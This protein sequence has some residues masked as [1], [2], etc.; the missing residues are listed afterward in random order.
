MQRIWI[1]ACGAALA[2]AA[3]PL[4][5]QNTRG[6]NDSTFVWSGRLSD[7]GVLTIKNIVGGISV[8]EASGD[9]VEVR[10]TKRARAG[11]D[12]RDVG[13]D[14]DASSASATICT[15]FRGDSACDD[16]NNFR[17]VRINVEYTVAM[18]RGVRL[19]ASTG[20]GELSVDRAGSDVDMRTGNGAVHVGQTEGRVS[21][22]T[23]NGEVAVESA[24][25]PVQVSSGNGRIFVSTTQGPVSA[26]TGN[27]DIDVRM[28]TL[29]SS[30]DMDFQSG[31]GTIR[32]TLPPDFNGQFEASTGNGDLR[33]DFEIQIRGRL[34]PQH[35]RGVIGNGGRLIRMQTGNGRIELRKG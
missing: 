8:V 7:G 25:G 4:N 22:A 14:V 34:D 23:G 28:K 21:V 3:A 9:R 16:G 10:A 35:M 5:A 27:G 26:Q 24:K 33:S 17:N 18:P 19:R 32:V 12:P 11:R 30:A 2:A 13:F 20:N 31:S 15:V 6:Q 29:T 1:L